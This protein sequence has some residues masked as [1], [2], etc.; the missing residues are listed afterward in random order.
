[1][2]FL[3]AVSVP[4]KNLHE[5]KSI[6]ETVE[7]YDFHYFPL[8]AIYKVVSRLPLKKPVLPS[9]A[10]AGLRIDVGEKINVLKLSFS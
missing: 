3:L 5:E 2:V 6:L 4:K 7:K 1:M 10:C 8:T 9:R